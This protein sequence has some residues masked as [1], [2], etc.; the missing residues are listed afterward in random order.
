MGSRIAAHFAN[1][2]V[3]SLLL[4]L[5]ADIARKGVE[6]AAKQR[7]GGF[8]VESAAALI[9]PGSFE[10]DLPRIAA[11][12]WVLEAITE[13]LE[14]KR[15]L[16]SKVDSVRAPHAILSTNTSGIPLREIAEGFSEG[17]RRRFLGTHFFNPPRYLHLLE[18]IPG[19]ATD[20]GLLEFVSGFAERRLGK[21][22]VRTKDTPN[23][24]ANRIGVFFM[25]AVAKLAVEED[26]TVEEVDALTGPLIGL[27]NSATL[28]LLDIIG[29]DVAAA[30][31]DNLYRAVPDDPW[32]ER[33]PLPEFHRKIL[34]R[35]WT[36][37]KS[38]QGY[39]KRVGPDRQIYALDLKTFEYHPA[40]KPKFP[41]LDSVRSIEDIGER[42][43]TL[44]Q[45][46]G[47][48]ETFLWKLLSDYFLYSAERIPEISDRI[49]EIDR[50]MRWGYAHK[51]GPFELW[52]AIGFDLVCSRLE[53]ESRK[54]PD[55][56]TRMRRQ[57]AL[58]FY[59]PAAAPKYFDF[60]TWAYQPFAEP[61]VILARL[62]KIKTNPGASLIDLGDGVLCIE[63]H[64]KVNALGEDH[65]RMVYA[66]LEE[67]E[68]NF[69]AAVIANQGEMFSAGANLSL[70]LLAAQNG[71]WD[72]LEEMIHRF[73][74]MNLALKYA[75]KPVVAAP[76]SRAL[77]GGCEVCL[78]A[79]RMQ[80]SAE[81][82]MGLVEVGVGVIPAAGG[83]KEMLARLGDARKAAELIGQAKVSTSAGNARELGFLTPMD[84]ISMNPDF[85]IDDAKDLALALARDY[86]PPPPAQIKVGGEAVYAA[87]KMGIWTYREGGYISEY[88][89]I[90]L[91][92]V[93]HVLS[94]GRL[95][96]E[97]MVPEQFLLDLERQEFLSLCGNQKTQERI[98]HM[99]K[100]GKPL[101][102]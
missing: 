100:T 80:A 36:G 14:I 37:E 49:V 54:I 5:T 10:A 31:A 44:L 23:F 20:P 13:N 48:A 74:Q 95:T 35:G 63:F 38:G 53:R 73:Q 70:V 11:C 19:P 58:S 81:T 39:Y 33:F 43:R 71:E 89:A 97:Q 12:D 30:V 22:V 90:V 72:E 47:R 79:A 41:S 85:L 34:E 65:F 21:G 3:P 42:L 96:E 51:L 92:K 84:R 91:E 1:T 87:L 62:N 16:W 88:D 61:G 93:A 102:N 83:C 76:F 68:K 8:F 25:G 45:H 60:E 24:I 98:Q 55:N 7:P 57:G 32:R 82:Y 75:K 15:S 86:T 101:R 40:A 2:G 94:G 99:L 64:T 46:S 18:L 27:P 17:F 77:G 4:D 59:Q 56:I 9:T 66:G 6:N 50:A 29:L 67:A 26:F 52:D 28:R 78:H 69:E